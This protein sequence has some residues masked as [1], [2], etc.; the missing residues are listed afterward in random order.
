M[1]VLARFQNI[2]RFSVEKLSGAYDTQAAGLPRGRT[3]L[4]TEETRE[5]Q[6]RRLVKA[7]ISAFAEKGFTATTI[8]DIVKRARVSKQVFYEIFENK[9]DCFLAADDLGRKALFEQVLS[10]IKLESNDADQWIRSSVRAYLHLCNSEQDFTKAWAIE[11]PNAGNRCREQRNLFFA[12]LGKRL[13]S[14]HTVIK[15]TQP[16][17]WVA[18]P[19]LFYDAAIGGAYE[20]IFRYICQNK[21]TELLDLEDDLVNFIQFSIGHKRL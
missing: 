1:L 21:F 16:D 18:V 4:L 8:T 13:K 17:Q 15:K 2:R 9:E 7:A 14:I 3:S 5:K 19:D 6:Q 12:E 10:D 20:I 11:F